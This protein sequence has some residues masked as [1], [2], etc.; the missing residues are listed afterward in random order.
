MLPPAAD[1]LDVSSSRHD[2]VH[3]MH[4][5]R[6]A[7]VACVLLFG[8]L[9][10]R[11]TCADVVGT[12]A[13]EAQSRAAEVDW[14]HAQAYDIILTEFHF[15]PSRIVLRHGQ[16]YAL[17]LENKGRFRH[18]FTAPEFFHAVAFRPGEAATEVEQSGGSFSLAAGEV[19]EIDFVPL[20][21]GTYP[22]DCT[23]PLHGLF[24]MTGDIIVE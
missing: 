2:G 5:F 9:A 15:A 10:A 7:V 1:M 20:Q 23:K 16:P 19:E 14:A 11:P 17:R 18:T 13:H 24:G 6:R 4:D 21:A 22:L 3:R 8:A 12:P